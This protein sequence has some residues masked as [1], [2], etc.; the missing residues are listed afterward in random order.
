MQERRQREAETIN[1]YHI[2]YMAKIDS[3]MISAP[4]LSKPLECHIYQYVCNFVLIQSGDQNASV[5][6]GTVPKSLVPAHDRGQGQWRH[7]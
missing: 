1:F 6:L 3:E 7:R 4:P 2:W 5:V